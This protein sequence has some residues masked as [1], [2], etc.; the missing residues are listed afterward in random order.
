MEVSSVSRSST[1]KRKH[2]VVAQIESQFVERLRVAKALSRVELARE[3][4]LAPSTAGIYVNRL[5]EKGFLVESES[6]TADSGR[7]PVLLTLNPRAGQFIG[8]DF[9]AQTIQA[10]SLDFAQ[11]IL[12]KS[13]APITKD[14]STET[15]LTKIEKAIESVRVSHLPL[16]G[17]GIGVP[18]FIDAEQGIALSYSALADWK[19]VPIAQHFKEKFK[20][21]VTLENNVRAM[22]LAELVFGQGRQLNNFICIAV[23][24][25]IGA[26]LVFNRQLYRG[27]N[28]S[29]GEIGLWQYPEADRSFPEGTY[30]MLQDM[31]SVRAILK[32]VLHLLEQGQPSILC[33]EADLTIDTVIDAYKKGD[34]VAYQVLNEAIMYL[35]WAAAQLTCALNPQKIIFTGPLARLGDRLTNQIQEYLQAIP[36]IAAVNRPEIACTQFEDFE[37]ALGATALAASS[38][39]PRY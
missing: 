19:N 2:Q 17:I 30:P 14:D 13:Q 20:V 7:P 28:S 38:W 4:G 31:A 1:V 9:E 39:S 16:H 21:P 18:G 22:A 5:I 11:K 24:S 23:R 8:V 27:Q 26:G 25:G 35:G 32:K 36:Y 12:L 10:I 15:I 37:G 29:A 33:P 34:A 3:F 6:T